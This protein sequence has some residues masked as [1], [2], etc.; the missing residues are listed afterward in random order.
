M[1][2]SVTTSE[3]AA[4]DAGP[5]YARGSQDPPW[6]PRYVALDY[7]YTAKSLA[8][9]GSFGHSIRTWCTSSSSEERD[10]PKRSLKS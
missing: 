7:L 10:N 6:P 3:V 9:L 2:A 4:T 8:L 1:S 5:R